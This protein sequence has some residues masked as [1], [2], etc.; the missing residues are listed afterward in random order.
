VWWHGVVANMLGNWMGDCRQTGKPPWHITNH[1]GQLSL[2]SLLGSKT[3][4]QH[5]WLGLRRA[6]SPASWVR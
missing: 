1:S 3:D 4:Y 2:S 6:R 5:A